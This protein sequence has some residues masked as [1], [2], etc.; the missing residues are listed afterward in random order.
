MEATAD[1][2]FPDFHSL[3]PVLVTSNSSLAYEQALRGSLVAGQ[4]KEGELATTSLEFEYLEQKSQF[5]MMIGE[6]D[7]GTLAHVFECLYTTFVSASR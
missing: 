6:D 3:F 4:E 2:S 5:E 1:C 7:I